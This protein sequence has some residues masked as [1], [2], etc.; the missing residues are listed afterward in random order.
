MEPGDDFLVV[1]TEIGIEWAILALILLVGIE[2]AIL[3]WNGQYHCTN[4]D[5]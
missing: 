4:Y 3:V 5:G 1:G 2:W